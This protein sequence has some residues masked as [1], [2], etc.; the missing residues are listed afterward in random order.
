V[1]DESD[2][3]EF[4]EPAPPLA[5]TPESIEACTAW[6]W[7]Q[8]TAGRITKGAARDLQMVVG[9]MQVQHKTNEQL[10]EMEKLRELVRRMEAAV[11]ERKQLEVGDRYAGTEVGEFPAKVEPAKDDDAD[12]PDDDK[13]E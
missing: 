3:D 1:S 11:R 13:D 4:T 5:A 2:D 9:R 10:H 7:R 8:V 6:V 12:D